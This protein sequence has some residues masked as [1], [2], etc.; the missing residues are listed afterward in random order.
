MSKEAMT[1]A[2]EALQIGRDYAES[3]RLHNVQGFKGYEHCAPDDAGSVKKIED[4]IKAIEIA[5]S[6]REA[7]AKQEQGEPVALAEYDA[8]LLND[9]GGGNVGWWLDYIRYELGRAHDHYQEQVADLYTTPQPKQEHG[10][11][12]KCCNHNCNEGRNC[13]LR[14]EI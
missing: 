4:A 9:Y 11:P 13:P 6:E 14:N 7:L 8:G 12:T 3:E 10:E 5:L 1:L 2:I